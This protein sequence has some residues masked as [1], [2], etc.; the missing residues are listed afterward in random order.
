MDIASNLVYRKVT[1]QDILEILAWEIRQEAKKKGEV[2]SEDSE[3]FTKELNKRLV[4]RQRELQG[5]KK[6][7]STRKYVCKSCGQSVRATREV[8][9]IC[10]KCHKAMVEDVKIAKE[11]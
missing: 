6:P 11:Q 1:L 4:E 9:I 5:G 7:S 10:G 8:D 3:E 2:I